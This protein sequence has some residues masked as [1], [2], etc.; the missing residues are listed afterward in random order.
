[1]LNRPERRN[2][3]SADMWAAIPTLMNS[4]DG[5]ADVRVIVLRGAGSEAFAAGADISE[6]AEA[7]GDAEAAASYEALNGAAFAAIRAARHPTIAM[8]EGYCI[9]GGLALALACD[10]RLAAP[11]AIFALPPARLGLAYPV[12]GL[13]DLVATVGLAQARELLFTAKRIGAEEALRIGLIN[14]RAPD[15]AV[16]TAR[17]C[18]EIAEGARLTILH[19]RRALGLIAGLPGHADEEEI[20]TLAR[21]CFNSADYGEG[22]AAF[23]AKR[24]PR[25]TGA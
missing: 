10:L 7:R 13:R 6:F 8:V 9:G 25:F 17:L 2:A 24:K 11:S 23:L 15:V 21:A 14:R 4:L 3:L 22:R 19:A 20:A 16:E 18:A 1:M 5:H 12:A